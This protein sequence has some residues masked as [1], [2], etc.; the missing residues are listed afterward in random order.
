M[1]HSVIHWPDQADL[2]L[3]PFALDYAAYLWNNMP[4]KDSKMAPLELFGSLKFSSYG[5]LNR[6]RVWGCPVY[7][8]DPKLQDGKK[9]PKW[10]PRSR[11]GQFL[12]VSK[13]HSSNIG[14]IL[15]LNTGAVSP[16]F[17]VVYDDLFSTVPNAELATPYIADFDDATW[18]KLVETGHDRRLEDED[19]NGALLPAPDLNEE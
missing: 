4:Q 11:R 13:Q 1:L 6:A 3:W 7:V 9:L 18:R 2:A 19:A 8:L 17:H 10:T 14:Q 15:N 16:Q 12:G 5:H